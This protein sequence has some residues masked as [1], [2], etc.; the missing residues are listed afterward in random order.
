MTVYPIKF[1]VVIPSYNRAALIPKTIQSILDQTVQDFEIIV[2]DDG[3]KDNT[4]EVVKAIADP[5]I[6]YYKKENGERGAARNY[7]AARS[8]GQYVT[9]IDSDDWMY[10]F[11][12]EEA[13]KII[14]AH[15]TPEIFHMS[16]EFVSPE[17]A[18]LDQ[19]F[20]EKDLNAQELKENIMGCIGVVVRNDII[21]TYRFSE[22]RRLS[23]T[24]DWLLWLRIGS[25]YPIYYSDRI[26]A[27]ALNH[28]ERS[29]LNYKEEQL[30][31]R[32]ELLVKY[33]KEDEHFVKT[34]GKH[35][36]RIAA[37]MYSYTAIHLALMKNR[38]RTVHYWLKA[39]KLNT[40][41]LFTRR[42]LAIMKRLIT[43]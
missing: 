33:L 11:Y 2:V 26:T 28:D 23:G 8:K 30:A 31:I 29:V 14:D 3:S 37:H 22:D 41:E 43:G 5:R 21:N 19:K 42:S 39:I 1:S 27:A 38:S 34:N 18:V 36:N 13:Q 16:Y 25:R 35:L 15:N 12:F 7:G 17:G 6:S 40:A 9:F 10:P 32:G 24:E 20:H 4:E